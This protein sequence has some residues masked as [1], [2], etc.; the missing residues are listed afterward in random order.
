M[1]KGLRFFYC[2]LFKHWWLG[3][4]TQHHTGEPF[5]DKTA[6]LAATRRLRIVLYA[7]EIETRKRLEQIDRTMHHLM[8]I[9]PNKRDTAIDHE[10][11][12]RNDR[13]DPLGKL[14]IDDG[15]LTLTT[16]FRWTDIYNIIDT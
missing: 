14:T 2:I 15:E 1:P 5:S 8:D 6:W 3:Y 16:N 10:L 9:N 12:R 7:Y 4:T 13:L 11:Q